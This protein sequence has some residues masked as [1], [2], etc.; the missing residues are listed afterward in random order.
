MRRRWF[1]QIIARVLVAGVVLLVVSIIVERIATIRSAQLVNAA[2]GDWQSRDVRYADE[3]GAPRWLSFV[4]LLSYP[5]IA[6]GIV[7]IIL[8]AV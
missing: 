5:G 3:G 2:G 7:L 8:G 6:A 1:G 4:G